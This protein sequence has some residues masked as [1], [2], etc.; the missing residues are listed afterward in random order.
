M[1]KASSLMIYAVSSLSFIVLLLFVIGCGGGGSG[2][3]NESADQTRQPTARTEQGQ[4][5]S[6]INTAGLSYVSGSQRGVTDS[7]GRFTYEVGKTVTF[8]VGSVTL[9]GTQGKSV[10]T[11]VD[12]VSR[13]SSTSRPAVNMTR[14]ILWTEVVPFFRQHFCFLKCI[15]TNA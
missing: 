5:K 10:I 14:L 1:R 6:A 9:G 8:S 15:P 13:G 4:F 12:L 7:R 2:G 11:P 3:G